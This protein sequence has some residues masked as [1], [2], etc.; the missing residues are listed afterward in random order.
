MFFR[1]PDLSVLH[2]YQEEVRMKSEMPC[3]S[4]ALRSANATL[5]LPL[6]VVPLPVS[7]SVSVGGEQV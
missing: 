1:L 5:K 2:L 3:Q 7:L 6:P 4:T